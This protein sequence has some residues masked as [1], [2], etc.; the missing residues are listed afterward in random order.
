MFRDNRV[1]TL[2]DTYKLQSF[3]LYYNCLSKEEDQNLK[4]IL[5]FPDIIDI[6]KALLYITIKNGHYNMLLQYLY[7]YHCNTDLI[8]LCESL[9]KELMKIH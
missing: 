2:L 8:N 6:A 5:S 3:L 9:Y 4:D 1:L 7:K